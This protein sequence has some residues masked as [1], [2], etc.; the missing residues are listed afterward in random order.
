MSSGDRR[1]ALAM[2]N[3]RVSDAE[4]RVRRL[5]AETAKMR[6]ALQQAEKAKAEEGSQNTPGPSPQ[7]KKG[8]SRSDSGG[9]GGGGGGQKEEGECTRSPI[10][11]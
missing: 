9:S 7:R 11:T 10:A 8:K 3:G 6:D 5:E 2:S 1:S 4:K